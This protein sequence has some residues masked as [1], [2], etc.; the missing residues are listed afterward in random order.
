MLS[1]CQPK[2]RR[3]KGRIVDLAAYELRYRFQWYCTWYSKVATL[4]I[5]VPND[6]MIRTGLDQQ[7][8]EA[9][10]RSAF[11]KS[12]FGMVVRWAAVHCNSDTGFPG[13][14]QCY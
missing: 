1:R 6:S 3:S 9:C 2:G 4:V 8:P 7:L 11:A 14:R 5:P 12:S 10:S 13:G